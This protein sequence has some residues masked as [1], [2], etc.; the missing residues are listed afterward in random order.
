MKKLLTL[1]LFLTGFLLIHVAV[2]AQNE[3]VKIFQSKSDDAC[4]IV[5]PS[6]PEPL[7]VMTS[8]TGGCTV[9]KTMAADD[10][11][12]MSSSTVVTT[13]IAEPKVAVEASTRGV[14]SPRDAASGL[15]TGKRQH[16]PVKLSDLTL[17][18][19]EPDSDGDGIEIYS[20]SWGMSNSGAMSSGTS[21]SSGRKAGY[22]VKENVK[23]TIA[24]GGGC[25]SEGTCT[26]TVSVDKKHTKSGHVTLLK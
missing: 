5:F 26:V 23:R 2:F 16:K 14:K 22:N 17:D 3:K 13:C 7:M 12:E 1:K 4:L 11:T 18:S 9:V 10:W 8:S 21:A 24:P 25:C 20:F 19:L 15:A 6:S